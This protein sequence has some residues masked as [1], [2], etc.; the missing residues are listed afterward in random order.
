MS[1]PSIGK[2]P[3]EALQHAARQSLETIQR[4]ML[5]AT[6]K[7]QGMLRHLESHLFAPDL[8]VRS[9][10]QACGIRDNSIALVFHQELKLS[11]KAYIT[12]RRM[13]TSGRLLIETRLHVW[14]IAEMVGYSTLG[15]FSKAFN[16]WA[17][18]R[19]R[20]Y[21]L[22]M[23]RLSGQ[24]L[25]TPLL[26]PEFL[27]RAVAGSLSAEEAKWLVGRLVELYP[28]TSAG[29]DDSPNSISET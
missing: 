8:N 10:K 28:E 5:R 1:K 19:P 29:G 15:V 14:Q 22:E 6:P 21:R 17:D 11:P 13:E 20:A 2:T 4:D 27:R 3:Q 18:Q 9:L 7:I 26:N 12:E 25:L 16:R 23:R 24:D